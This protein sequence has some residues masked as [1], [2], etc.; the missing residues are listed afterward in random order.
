ME[1]QSARLFKR[2]DLMT[3]D[4]QNTLCQ[5]KDLLEKTADAGMKITFLRLKNRKENNS[6]ADLETKAINQAKNLHHLG[7]AFGV[8]SD[9]RFWVLSAPAPKPLII[10]KTQ[11]KLPIDEL[12]HYCSRFWLSYIPWHGLK[13]LKSQNLSLSS[14]QLKEGVLTLECLPSYVKHTGPVIWSMNLLGGYKEEE[15]PFAMIL[16]NQ[17][18]PDETLLSWI[19]QIRQKEGL[20][21]LEKD[22]HIEKAINN[23]LLKTPVHLRHDRTFLEKTKKN[24]L[25][26]QIIFVGENKVFGENLLQTGFLLWASSSHRMLLLNQKADKI[27]A[28]VK[29]TSSGFFTVLILAQSLDKSSFL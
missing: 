12:K 28:V 18:H 26:Q 1:G 4:F 16:K 19:N 20:E 3:T 6:L 25:K 27:G 10:E 29:K 14:A 21:K 5:K 11:L 23:Y 7:Y 9:H 24:L 8:C 2:Q 15:T 17:D 22:Q 13:I